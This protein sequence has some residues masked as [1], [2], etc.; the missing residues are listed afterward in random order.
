MMIQFIYH[1]TKWQSTI[2]SYRNL[3][4]FQTQTIAYEPLAKD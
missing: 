4:F 1:I 2:I 3:T